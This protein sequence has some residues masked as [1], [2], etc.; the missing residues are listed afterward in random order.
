MSIHALQLART[1]LVLLFAI[2]LTA[3]G[4]GGVVNVDPSKSAV[5]TTNLRALPAEYMARKAVAYSPFRSNNRDTEVI[6]EA[7]VREDLDLLIEGKFR[8]IRLFD[9][10]D[11]VA[12]LVLD[13]I[14]DNDLD[15]KVQLGSYPLS[16]R[17]EPNPYKV[18]ATK[19]FNMQELDRQ[20]AL[21]NN[22]KYSDIILALSVGNETMVSWSPVPIEQAVMA[23]YIRYVRDRTTLP[24]TTDDDYDFFAV[25]P[26]R[27]TDEIDFVAMH[28]YANIY[29]KFP[30]GPLYWDWKQEGVAAGPARAVA[31]MDEAIVQTR[32]RFQDVR[33]ALDNNGLHAMPIAITENGW[34][35]VD[36]GEQGFR[37]HPANQKMYVSRLDALRT[38]GRLGNGPVNIFYFEAFDEPW[39]RGDDGWGLF[40]VDRKARYVVQNLYPPAKW[41]TTFTDADAVFYS[42][43]V[44]RPAFTG[45][46]YTI[47][48]EAA[49]AVNQTGLSLDL[50]EPGIVAL[51]DVNTT[52]APG[53]AS[54]SIEIMPNPKN[55]G[56]G[57]LYQGAV[58]PA[59]KM[60]PTENLSEFEATGR[61]NISIKTAY[62]GKIEIG[63]STDTELGV[64][65][66]VF[67]QIGN[68][69]Y[70]YCNTDT[71]CQVSI[72]LQAFKAKNPKID[73]SLMKVRLF[74]ADRYPETGKPLD[75]DI[76]TKLNID[77]MY[78]SR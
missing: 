32:R 75:S 58:D 52:S 24:V 63:L 34:N 39:K 27:I 21:A 62:P 54:T 66:E 13:I 44:A 43:P 73:F 18:E 37:A 49:G 71:W 55:Y 77:G 14:A 5:S 45:N 42:P 56:W 65:Q 8:L 15:M 61:L 50:F 28:T 9:S 16:Y 33:N 1:A 78:Y 17:F 69:D 12:K 48:S 2:V 10:S 38:D 53:D 51:A 19:A 36:L 60:R 46:Q 11:K 74:V 7:M 25:P 35:A 41:D 23:G 47:F 6:T 70:G 64:T 22:P 76:R 3:C 59:T 57:F 20:I 4:G 72:P 67:L 40:T 29:T 30:D 31:M 26:K 68:G